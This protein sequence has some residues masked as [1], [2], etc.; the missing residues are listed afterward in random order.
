MCMRTNI[1]LDPDLL[2]AAGRYARA[3][4]KKGIVEEALRTFV[5]VRAAAARAA[6][7]E[8]RVEALRRRTADLDPGFSAHAFIRSERESRR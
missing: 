7:Y 1:V 6:A 2:A 3:T 8:A 5:E 4:T